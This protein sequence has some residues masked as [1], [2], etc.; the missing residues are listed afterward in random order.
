MT[1][2]VGAA[3]AE[4][5]ANGG[6]TF[7]K[8]KPGPGKSRDAVATDQKLRL[9]RALSSLTAE[10][11]FEAVT[12]RGLL[13]RAGIS[14]SSFYKH[15]D[16]I[17]DCFAGIVGTTVRSVVDDITRT[18]G[19]GLDETARL[20]TALRF[21]MERLAA[22]PAVT[23]AVFIESSSAGTQVLD[24]MKAALSE[25]EALLS[26][27]LTAAPRPATGT[28]RLAGG[29]VAGMVGIIRKTTLAGRA[30][31]LPDLADELA[32]W[33]FSIAHE[34]VVTF[35][36]L[37]ARPL[38]GVFASRLPAADSEPASPESVADAGKRA[39]ATAARL[40]VSTGLGGLTSAKIRKDAGLSR[41]EFEAHF[42][43]VEDCYL[44]AIESVSGVFV[45][46]AR[47]SADGV[48]SWE[49]WVFRMMSALCS[50]AAAD[51]DL[52]RLVLLDV[53]AVGRP[54][55]LRR[56]DLI[57]RAATYIREQA[58]PDR[59]PSEL[60]ATASVS[61]I[62]RIAETEVAGQR[63]AQLPRV[64]PAFVYMIL[65]ARRASSAAQQPRIPELRVAAADLEAVP[66]A[67]STA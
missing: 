19:L 36:V 50:L 48:S 7:E 65:A 1:N 5:T 8:L 52:S 53:T 58:D 35:S 15:Y 59:R 43:G 37:R 33:V 61:A 24:E 46:A 56:E 9:R 20:R 25:V 55:L 66:L 39:I 44:D 60:A 45:E 31:E 18:Q 30:T 29:L 12:V 47:R 22:E 34:E 6:L 38:S 21:W 16:S 42:T 23:D 27:T 10:A 26:N 14:S 11:G 54:G 32:D 28:T 4:P 13:R 67:A 2:L 62:W 57:D 41:R 64:A 40:A 51:R 17:E 63:S 49:R 3:V